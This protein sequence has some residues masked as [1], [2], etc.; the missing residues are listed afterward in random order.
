[1]SDAFEVPDLVEPVVGWR[2][3]DVVEHDNGVRLCSVAFEAV[4]QPREPLRAECRRTRTML[5]WSQL[6]PHEAPFA[7]CA[8]GVY[9]ARSLDLAARYLS[10]SLLPLLAGCRP[11]TVHRVIG[12]VAL[13]GRV[14]EAEAGWRA[15]SAYPTEL[16]VPEP[17]GRRLGPLPS[18]VPAPRLP[19][20]RIAEALAAYGAHVE[21]VPCRS[22]RG[23]VAQLR[24]AEPRATLLRRLRWGTP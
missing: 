1:M 5:A 3:W 23:L 17:T 24:P 9:A 7:L 18:R 14:V 12:R 13:W 6:A 22:V 19:A 16:Y 11:R 8:C 4:W 20:G 10:V 21:V 2:V 15:G